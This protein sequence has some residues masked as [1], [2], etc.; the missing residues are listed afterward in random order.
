MAWGHF[1]P[2]LSLQTAKKGR[3]S[4]Q[5]VAGVEGPGESQVP[6]GGGAGGRGGAGVARATERLS[7]EGLEIGC[8]TWQD[9]DVL[10]G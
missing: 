9:S 1:V 2:L 4:S 6:E 5:G 8:W 7:R 3:L 10:V